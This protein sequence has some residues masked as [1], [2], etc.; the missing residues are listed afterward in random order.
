MMV[1]IG[2]DMQCVRPVDLHYCS[3]FDDDCD[4]NRARGRV[5]REPIAYG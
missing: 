5:V 2:G 4:D 3:A 1:W